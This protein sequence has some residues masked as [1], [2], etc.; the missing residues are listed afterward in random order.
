L[1]QPLCHSFLAALLKTPL[2]QVMDDMFYKY[3]TAKALRSKIRISA[4]PKF[5]Y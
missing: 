5:M 2:D 3:D 4:L 1:L